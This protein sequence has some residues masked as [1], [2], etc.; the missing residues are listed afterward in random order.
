[1]SV[2]LEDNFC[3]LPHEEWKDHK[4]TVEE[5]TKT[6]LSLFEKYDVKATFFVV[7][8]IAE[9]HP[10]L[11]KKI[12]ESGHEIAS[13]SFFH[14]DVRTMSKNIFE[15]DLKN[16]ID[17]LEKLSGQKVIGYRAPYYSI[18]NDNLWV[19]DILKKYLKYD[20]S[21]FPVKTPLYG[22]PNA[23]RFPYHVSKNNPLKNDN[24]EKFLEIPPMTIG[25]PYLGNI[26]VAGGFYLRFFPVVLIKK[27]IKNF[28]KNKIPA[29]CYIHPHDLDPKRPKIPGNPNRAYWG[30]KNSQKKFES[31]LSNFRFSSV[32]K[33]FFHD[34]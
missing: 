10:Q 29:M 18:T 32:S 33:I 2:D 28:N 7:A 4:S 13:H 8:K 16:S 27:G 3:N 21:I 34:V 11:I 24:N 30:I 25:I 6:I 20:S 9:L 15:E 12:V 22:I 26:P 17:T 23:Q 19:F 5:N 1:M 31:I 14:K